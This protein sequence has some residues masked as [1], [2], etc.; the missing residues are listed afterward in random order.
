MLR[1]LEICLSMLMLL[2]IHLYMTMFV[3]AV[4]P[5]PRRHASLHVTI[6]I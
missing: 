1:I 2:F 5:W 4:P 6:M 3:P